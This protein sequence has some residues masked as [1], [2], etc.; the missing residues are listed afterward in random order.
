MDILAFQVL[1]VLG[2][3]FPARLIQYLLQHPA[4]DASL[5]FRI[6]YVDNRSVSSPT[7]R[8]TCPLA[9]NT[10]FGNI[11]IFIRSDRLFQV[12]GSFT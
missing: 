8:L 3:L 10:Y 5:L 2:C 6:Q 7:S 1:H 12:L 9:I 11:V 4:S